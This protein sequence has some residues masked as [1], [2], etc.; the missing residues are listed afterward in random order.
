MKNRNAQPGQVEPYENGSK[1]RM[2]ATGQH[3]RT[4][5]S[6]CRRVSPYLALFANHG[7][8][9]LVSLVEDKP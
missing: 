7:L 9:T 8:D 4:A 1:P 5:S 2:A 3:A 6:I